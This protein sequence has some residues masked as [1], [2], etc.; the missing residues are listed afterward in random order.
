MS[1][2]AAL[3]H[4]E[5]Q[6]QTMRFGTLSVPSDELLSFP[7]GLPGFPDVRHFALLPVRDGLAWLQSAEI[8]AL[9]FLLVAAERLGGSRWTGGPH[10]WA[11]VTFGRTPAEA[12]ANLMAPI[13]IDPLTHTA[14]QIIS[15]TTDF[16]T[17]EPLDLSLI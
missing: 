2:V 17:T 7:E 15:A 1:A 6:V 9:A 16:T 14:R 13:E 11:I 5:I 4:P 8:P 12:S 3:Q 10:T